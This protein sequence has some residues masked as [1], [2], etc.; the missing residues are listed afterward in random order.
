MTHKWDGET[1]GVMTHG[2]CVMAY[3]NETL[4]VEVFL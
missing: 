2:S 4:I 3:D 1:Q